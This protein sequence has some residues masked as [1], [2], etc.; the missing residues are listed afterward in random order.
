[1]KKIFI[2][3]TLIFWIVA[4]VSAI[5]IQIWKSELNNNWFFN[6]FWNSN[7]TV[8]LTDENSTSYDLWRRMDVIQWYDS[9]NF[10]HDSYTNIWTWV[11]VSDKFWDFYLK[12]GSIQLSDSSTLRYECWNNVTYAFDGTLYSPSFWT[13]TIQ[14]GSYYCPLSWSASLTL[15]SDLLWYETLDWNNAFN[16]IT[17]ENSR[18]ELVQILENLVFDDKKISINGSH[19]IK[20]NAALASDY[21]SDTSI[22]VEYWVEWKMAKFNRNVDRNLVKYTTWL[23]PITSNYSLDWFGDLSESN[24]IHY[25]DYEWQEDFSASNKDNKWKI[26][27]LW[28]WGSGLTY[29]NIVVR[30]Q[31]LLY[32]KWWNLY[33]DA[34]IRNASDLSQLVIVVKRDSTNKYNWGNVYIDPGVTNID[35]TIIAD[36]SIIWF[37]WSDVVNSQDNNIRNQLLIYGS[38]STKNT[39]WED[40]ATYGTDD[41]IS[42]SWNE[43]NWVTTYNLANLRWFQVMLNDDVLS[44]NCAYDGT[45]KIVARADSWTWVLEYAFAGKKDCF[46]NWFINNDLRGTDKLTPLVIEYNPNIQTNP[47]FILEK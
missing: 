43:V 39:F 11:L 3:I 20:D 23:Y 4:T 40:I 41:Y 29:N 12:D 34:D 47:H 18:W 42:N 6:T 13:V 30:W 1:M 19:N 25:Y 27:T 9:W 22:D 26:L 15:Y 31:K 16:Y 8:L 37:D 36:W 21:S 7:I 38:I 45:S 44:W 46:F 17:I 33:I 24:K 14:N 10:G 28:L 32:I 35:A 5:E 2:F